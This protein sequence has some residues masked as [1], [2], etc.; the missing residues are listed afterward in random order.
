MI[1]TSMAE[2]APISKLGDDLV[3][4]IL[5]RNFPNL[6]S[7]CRSKPVCKRWNS[8]ISHARS[9][10]R[11]MSNHR[12]NNDGQ[13]PLLLCKE[14]PLPSLLSFLQYPM[15]SDPASSFG[16]LSRT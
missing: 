4:E 6:R 3:E 11:F 8:L 13:P 12:S 14:N 10:R 2:D 1:G 9:N 15:N 5:I 16:I 7:A